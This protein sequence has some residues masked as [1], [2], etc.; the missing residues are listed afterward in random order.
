MI[1]I[2]E[3]LTCHWAARRIQRY[4]D[5]DPSAPLT[6]DDV[7]RLEAHL[8][9]CEKCSGILAENRALQRSLSLWSGGAVDQSAVDRLH[10]F[11]NQLESLEESG[12]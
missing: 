1:A 10:S 7:A 5:S 2:R 8:S 9:T 3:M 4:L 11:L 6:P 12:R